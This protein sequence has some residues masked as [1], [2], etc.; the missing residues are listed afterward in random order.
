MRLK[1]SKYNQRE[2]QIIRRFMFKMWPRFQDV[3]KTLS[4]NQNLFHNIKTVKSP[5]HY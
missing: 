4:D 2:T 1:K 3:K 5:A